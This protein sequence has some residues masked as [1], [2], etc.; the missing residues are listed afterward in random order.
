MKVTVVVRTCNRPKFL[1]EALASI[2][3]Q[4]HKDWEVL[5]FDDG[6]TDENFGIFK[7]F[8]NR[9]IDK[10]IMYLT[11]KSTYDMFQNSWLLAPDLAEGEIMV[12]LDDDDILAEDC[13]E[14]LSKLYEENPELEFSYGSSITFAND[15][16]DKVIQTNTCFDHEKTLH[17]WAAYTIPNNKPWNIPWAFYRNYYKEPRH[18]TSIIHCAKDNMFCIFHTYVMRTASVKRVKDKITVTSKF[19]DDLEFMGSLD[20]LGLGQAALKKILSFVRVH[21]EGRVSDMGRITNNTNIFDENF[22]I[23]DKVD[24]LRPSGFF[25]RVIPLASNENYN[26]GVSDE[27]KD[28]FKALKLKIKLITN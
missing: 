28:K 24:E 17:E 15:E 6:A 14:F 12:R 11:T 23:R 26:D 20:Y 1:K 8:K 10:R 7:N 2:E 3:L 13:L 4:T 21:G 22:R 18:L 9:N 25:S 16:L 27:L 19:V 5:I